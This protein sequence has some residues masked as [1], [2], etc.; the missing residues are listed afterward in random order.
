MSDNPAL[1][2]WKGGVDGS[3]VKREAERSDMLA[4]SWR[5]AAVVECD[6]GDG[7]A[8]PLPL[9]VLAERRRVKG[10]VQNGKGVGTQLGLKAGARARAIRRH[11]TEGVVGVRPRGGEALLPVGWGAGP[12]GASDTFGHGPRSG[13][14]AR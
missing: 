11:P 6:A 3:T 1:P 13:A 14:T 7:T 10:S 9:L 5:G 8:A 4:E 2:G 12:G